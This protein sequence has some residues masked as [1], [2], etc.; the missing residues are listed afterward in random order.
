LERSFR[1]LP[2]THFCRVTVFDLLSDRELTSLISKFLRA[3]KGRLRPHEVEY[4]A[5][6]EWQSDQRHH[7]LLVRTL[8]DLGSDLFGAVLH[9]VLAGLQHTHYCRP[10]ESPAASA[11]YVV[12]YLRDDTRAEVVPESFSGKVI[13]Y[14]RGFLVRPRAELWR[15]QCS[16]WYPR[17]PG[18]C[19]AR[20]VPTGRARP[21][22]V[23]LGAP[24]R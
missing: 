18:L 15:E 7:H 4:L 17:D 20:S 14:S 8:A 6:S 12:K 16:E 11:R 5:V 19:A 3:L 9:K 13:T 24:D 22:P 10:V 1:E 23:S 21:T 2:P